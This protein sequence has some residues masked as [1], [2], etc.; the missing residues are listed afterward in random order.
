LI[1]PDPVRRRDHR[2]G[3]SDSIIAST[4]GTS[5]NARPGPLAHTHRVNLEADSTNKKE[6][7]TRITRMNA[8][9]TKED[10]R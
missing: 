2:I 5:T 8:D 4:D 1:V 10:S 9:K 7:W 6:T 3:P